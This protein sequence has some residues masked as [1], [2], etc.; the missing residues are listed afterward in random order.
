MTL[1]KN[2]GRFQEIYVSLLNYSESGRLLQ[3]FLSDYFKSR[4]I[5]LKSEGTTIIINNEVF[6]LNFESLHWALKLRT[7]LTV[8]APP[9]MIT[10]HYAPHPVFGHGLAPG[11]GNIHKIS[12]LLRV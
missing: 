7:L 1:R 3:N 4:H 10:Q 2:F 6:F 9:I 8:S 11:E 5:Y 12:P